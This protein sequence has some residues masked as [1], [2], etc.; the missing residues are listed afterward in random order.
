LPG[1]LRHAP[2]ELA[3][4]RLDVKSPEPIQILSVAGG[5][6]D[7]LLRLLLILNRKKLNCQIEVTVLDKDKSALDV[8]AKIAE[9]VGVSNNFHWVHGQAK[10]IKI[11]VPGKR[12]DIIEIVGLL[13]YFPNERAK[14]VIAWGG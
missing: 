9:E 4:K 12:F 13:D 7:L 10:D 14:Q 5:S 3:N 8:G 1:L 2:W 11:L 6:A